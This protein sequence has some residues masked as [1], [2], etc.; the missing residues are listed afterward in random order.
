MQAAFWLAALTPGPQVSCCPPEIVAKLF[1]GYAD[2]FDENL[3]NKLHYRTPAMLMDTILQ[4]SAQQSSLQQAPPAH[5]QHTDDMFAATPAQQQQQQRFAHC[6]DL[7][8]GTGLMGPLLRPHTQ[9]LAGV[10]LS[11]GMVAKAQ[12]RGCYDVLAVDELVQY[13]EG[14]A[15]AMEQ[16]GREGSLLFVCWSSVCCL[17]PQHGVCG[18]CVDEA[19][20]AASQ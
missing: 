5:Q 20:R 4:H 10:D 8:C 2:H 11:Q 17:A 16:H 18:S 19:L 6:V 13:L 14:A 9:R 1:D 12:E 3:T 7:G 15:A